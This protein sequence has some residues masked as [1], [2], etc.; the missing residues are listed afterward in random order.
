MSPPAKLSSSLNLYQASADADLKI[1]LIQGGWEIRRSFS[2]MGIYAGDQIR[3]LCKA[4]FG[5]PL[6]LENRGT[7]VAVSKQL[8]EQIRVEA[9]P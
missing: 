7:K 6:V 8:A 2:Q 1:L 4:P 5:G 9:I 3:V